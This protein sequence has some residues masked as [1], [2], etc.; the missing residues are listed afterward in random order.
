MQKYT[1]KTLKKGKDIS[2]SRTKTTGLDF[3]WKII[4]IFNNPRLLR[5]LD[6]DYSCSEKGS[7][8]KT[9]NQFMHDHEE[10][11]PHKCSIC[12]YS[13][14][15]KVTLRKHIKS[16]ECQQNMLNGKKYCLNLAT[17][18]CPSAYI[19]K[20]KSFVLLTQFSATVLSCVSRKETLLNSEK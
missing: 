12:D 20:Q 6:W 3:W 19:W 7:L 1:I 10:M 17:F 11:K 13:F 2:N 14:S 5:V 9:L 16:V 4:S 8:K 18:S 15:V